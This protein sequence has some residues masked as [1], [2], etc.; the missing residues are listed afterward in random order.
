MGEA[1]FLM[2]RFLR[3]VGYLW[4]G[5][6]LASVFVGGLGLVIFEGVGKFLEI[7]G[8]SN[9]WNW[10]LIAILALPGLGLLKLADR[11]DRS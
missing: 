9:L 6:L 5:L 11:I 3:I 1:D 10:G 8:P 2:A 4:L 7:F